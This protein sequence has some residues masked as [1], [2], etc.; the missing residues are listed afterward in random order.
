MCKTTENVRL[1][2]KNAN[3]INSKVES[4]KKRKRKK[5]KTPR[6]TIHY[7]TIDAYSH[8]ALRILTGSRQPEMKERIYE[9]TCNRGNLLTIELNRVVRTV[10]AEKPAE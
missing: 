10:H 9:I 3:K 6:D 5:K 8:T 2:G 4:H 7:Y 1:H